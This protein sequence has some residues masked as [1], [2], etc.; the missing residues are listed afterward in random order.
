MTHFSE[1][2]RY[3]EKPNRKICFRY[4]IENMLNVEH[5][6]NVGACVLFLFCTGT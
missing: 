4:T 5:N 3:V 6:F 1:N 2:L